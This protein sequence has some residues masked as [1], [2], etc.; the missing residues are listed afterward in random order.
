[1][2]Y[3]VGFL[4]CF[5]FLSCKK[6]QQTFHENG[7]VHEVFSI[8][9]ENKRHGVFTRYDVEGNLMETAHYTHGKLDGERL[10]YY[11]EGMKEI[12]EF[13]NND[14][15]E[16]MY[17]RFDKEGNLTFEAPYTNN[18]LGGIAKSY[19]PDGTL[20]EEVTFANNEENGPFTEYHEN[21]K[22][23]WKGTYRNGDNEFGLLEE[24]DKNGSLI[25]KLNCDERGICKTI[26][27]REEG[28][29]NESDTDA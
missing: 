4:A 1:M 16:G 25:K 3:I 19:Y 8:D 14:Q 2:K 11:P 29:I 17:K 13:Y 22:I 24:Y 18:V 9:N 27:T 21:G 6:E 7:K 15:L 20:K 26:W 23:A 12:S 28:E 5:S 10:I